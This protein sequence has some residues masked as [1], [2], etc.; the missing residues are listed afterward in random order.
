MNRKLELTDE[1]AQE[2]DLLIKR[3]LRA[4]DVGLHHTRTFAYKDVIKARIALLNQIALKLDSS[5]NPV[6]G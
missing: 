2:L 4:S 1:E 3:E 5:A 6:E